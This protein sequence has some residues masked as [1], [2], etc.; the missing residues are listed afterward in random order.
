M[1]IK[2]IT[3]SKRLNE[4]IP[5]LGAFLDLLISA[6]PAGGWGSTR[7]PA[8]EVYRGALEQG[9]N[10]GLAIADASAQAAEIAQEFNDALWTTPGSQAVDSIWSKYAVN[11]PRD[12]A[13]E[14]NRIRGIP[15]F[16]TKTNN[17]V[18]DAGAAAKVAAK[19]VYNSAQELASDLSSVVKN[20]VSPQTLSKIASVSVKYAL[21]AAAIIALLYGG[22]KLYSYLRNKKTSKTTSALATES[23]GG[24]SAGSIATVANPTVA[25]SKKKAKSVSA[26]DSNVSLFG[27]KTIKR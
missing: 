3:E 24:M 20:N 21:P 8:D 23:A 1:K 7:S 15:D 2:E 6:S 18:S 10:K 13:Q 19:G 4:G 16:I 5:I 14:F 25:R 12:I 9:I 17:L 22:S 26:L 11:A 27:G